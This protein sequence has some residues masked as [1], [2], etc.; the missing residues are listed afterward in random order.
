MNKI[1]ALALVLAA[2]VAPVSVVTANAQ[3]YGGQHH[4]YSDPADRN[5]GASGP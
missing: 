4:N 3:S 2:L 5:N 1:L